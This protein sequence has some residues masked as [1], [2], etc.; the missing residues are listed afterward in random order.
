MVGLAA[1]D[2]IVTSAIRIITPPNAISNHPTILVVM[3]D[4]NKMGAGVRAARIKP[5]VHTGMPRTF[6]NIKVT[7][8]PR[9]S[10]HRREKAVVKALPRLN[11][12]PS[13]RGI[14]KQ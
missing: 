2:R 6:L 4:T 10:P 8:E 3:V 14:R 5:V 12:N 7:R 11:V 9:R 1:L 13:T